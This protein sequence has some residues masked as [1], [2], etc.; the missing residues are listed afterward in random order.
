LS[1]TN[2]LPRCTICGNANG[3][4]DRNVMELSIVRGPGHRTLWTVMACERCVV[5]V[6]EQR[7]AEAPAPKPE[8][9]H[10]GPLASYGVATGAIHG[11]APIY[12]PAPA[13]EWTEEQRDAAQAVAVALGPGLL[14]QAYVDHAC[15]AIARIA[16]RFVRVK[17]PPQRAEPP[18]IDEPHGG[19]SDNDDIDRKSYWQGR[20][21]GVAAGFNAAI[22]ECVASLREQGI[23]V[24]S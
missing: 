10:V 14:T 9:E 6:V 18:R 17:L 4:M 22:K 12:E 16:P 19:I 23:E 13:R 11:P 24:E 1:D 7:R 15:A 2:S 8:S 20:D 5:A 3:V 21:A